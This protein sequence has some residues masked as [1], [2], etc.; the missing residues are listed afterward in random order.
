MARPFIDKIHST[1]LIMAGLQNTVDFILPHT[2]PDFQIRSCVKEVA[3]DPTVPRTL[4]YN[5]P[6]LLFRQVRCE[7]IFNQ[8][9]GNVSV[10][11]G[12]G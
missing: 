4:L 7:F 3:F 9:I 1:G 2:S 8:I 12:K 10:P 5:S 6:L 11:W